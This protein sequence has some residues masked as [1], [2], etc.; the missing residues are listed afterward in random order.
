MLEIKVEHPST[1]EQR[2]A[3]D[4]RASTKK[5]KQPKIQNKAQTSNMALALPP[6]DELEGFLAISLQDPRKLNDAANTT[7]GGVVS[8]LVSVL[9]KCFPQLY[10]IEKIATCVSPKRGLIIPGRDQE[11]KWASGA[12]K[13][14]PQQIFQTLK[15]GL[16]I[17]YYLVKKPSKQPTLQVSARFAA[18][19]AEARKTSYV[20]TVTI[21]I[22]L[23]YAAAS[24]WIASQVTLPV[25][26]RSL[27]DI[28]EGNTCGPTGK[29]MINQ[30]IMVARY[31]AM[32][33]YLTICGYLAD[34]PT[35][36][37]FLPCVGREA[38]DFRKMEEK[39]KSRHGE[40]FPF[41]KVLGLEGNEELSPKRYPNLFAV[42]VRHKLRVDRSF[43]SYTFK[44]SAA[45]LLSDES[46]DD[47]LSRPL[48]RKTPCREEDKPHI[49]RIFG[50]DPDSIEAEDTARE[51]L[52]ARLIQIM[53]NVPDA[54]QSNDFRK[55]EEKQAARLLSSDESI[56]DAL[57]RPLKRKAQCR[58]EDKPHI[59][60]IFG[61]DPDSI[62]AEDTGRESL[63]AR[64]IQDIWPT[65]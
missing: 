18:M 17:L 34:D 19:L 40:Q 53:A 23:D 56:D 63:L 64:L 24:A 33:P 45:C 43:D 51:S 42:A 20:P 10:L 14:T 36:A 12:N 38:N 27:L 50:I 22:G 3:T 59:K 4:R 44:K 31:A 28:R 8:I 15:M 39:L 37:A 52:L 57:S 62:D 16:T 46:I 6:P 58:E 9:L 54:M 30:I 41:I 7:K 1:S 2:K 5:K 55:M 21:D 47:V 49:K 25:A 65:L 32:T 13:L 29:A 48:K 35:E 60:R 11:M 61:I 26:F